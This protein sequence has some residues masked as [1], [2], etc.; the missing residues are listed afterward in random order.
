MLTDLL[1]GLSENSLEKLKA[2]EPAERERLARV[3]VS[4][5]ELGRAL[6]RES[7][8]LRQAFGEAHAEFL[9]HPECRALLAE[10]RRAYEQ[11]GPGG[12]KEAGRG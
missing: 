4:A 3:M 8:E 12:S 11:F 6:L 1:T 9:H 10:A 2:A 5:M 7:P